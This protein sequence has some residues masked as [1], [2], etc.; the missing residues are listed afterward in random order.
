MHKPEEMLWEDLCFFA[1]Q[2]AEK[3]IKAVLVF[4]KID[5]PK[6]HIIDELFELLKASGH[7]VPSAIESAEDLTDYAAG[8]RYPS[9]D[10]PVTK[11][12]YLKAFEQARAV[13]K[14]AQEVIHRQG[15]GKINPARN[16]KEQGE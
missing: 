7:T 16:P 6:T 5:F 9:P 8:F 10:E 11:E 1:Q 14:W 4:Y 13:V 3:A 12:E 2:A 15:G